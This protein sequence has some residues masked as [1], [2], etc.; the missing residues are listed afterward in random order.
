[1]CINI[2][3]IKKKKESLSKPCSIYT[4]PFFLVFKIFKTLSSLVSLSSFDSLPI[5]VN[6]TSELNEPEL[7]ILSKG[8][9]AIKSMVNQPLRYLF[10][11]WVLLR[12][13]ERSSMLM[14]AVLKQTT[15]SIIKRMSTVWFAILQNLVSS[16]A[17]K[18]N[19]IGSVTHENS[20][21]L[22]MKMF[23]LIKVLL[24]G[25]IKKKLRTRS[26]KDSYSTSIGFSFSFSM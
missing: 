26:K 3:D 5:L 14:K 6:L 19:C 9:M 15:I 23:H 17:R 4:S 21:I 18:A 10:V 2:T 7:R 11:I 20:R 13:I 25:L 8:T 22:E 12:F 24:S 16:S 1:M